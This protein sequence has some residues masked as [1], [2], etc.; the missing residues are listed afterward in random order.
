VRG[1]AVASLGPQKSRPVTD[2]AAR[3]RPE[4][5]PFAFAPTPPVPPLL[6]KPAGRNGASE[7]RLPV[8]KDRR[9]VA[10][11]EA[12]VALAA[13]PPVHTHLVERKAAQT[14]RGRPPMSRLVLQQMTTR[15]S[16][17]LA[18][19]SP[20]EAESAPWPEFIMP[21]A[22][23]RVT[24][25]FNQGRRHPAID[26][27]GALGSSVL[28]T[29]SGQ[30]VV[31]AGWRGGY[32]NAVITQDGYGW[33]HLYGHLKSITSRVGQMLSQGEKLGHLGSTGHSTGPHVHY[34]VRNAKGQHINPVT[35][36]FPGRS[37]SKG[38][39]WSD[40]G[41]FGTGV[42]VAGRSVAVDRV[43]MASQVEAEPPRARAKRRYRS[44]ESSYRAQGYR[45]AGYS[46]RAR[47]AWSD[48][49][50]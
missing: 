18:T 25:L 4:V 11:E 40:V 16:D 13:N 6:T 14:E 33:T 46:H 37:V 9:A 34:E 28:A 31:F 42:Q 32:G 12:M 35:L 27:A 1:V 45:T 26:L 2:A 7:M 36:L 41:Q 47:R 30:K 24:S 3:A 19:L 22:G 15:W 5:A 49:G 48:G 17:P 43:A 20:E 23:G 39:A 21:F 10:L 50:E 29:T 38:L 8:L 44:P